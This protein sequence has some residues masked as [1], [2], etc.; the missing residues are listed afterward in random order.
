MLRRI[1]A[2]TLLVFLGPAVAGLIGTWLPSVGIMPVL[3]GTESPN[4][5]WA[6]RSISP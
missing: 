3:G 5:G 1:P 6:A 4:P 2:L